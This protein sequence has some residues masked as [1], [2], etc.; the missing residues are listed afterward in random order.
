MSIRF[1]RSAYVEKPLF[2][3]GSLMEDLGREII[4]KGEIRDVLGNVL[5]EA[6]CTVVRLSM[7]T[8]N[9]ISAP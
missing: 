9:S 1:I 8:M 6:R 3:V 2:I 4:I 5:T 7:E